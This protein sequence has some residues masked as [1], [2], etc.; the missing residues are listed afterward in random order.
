MSKN[1]V[2]WLLRLGLAFVFLYAS[3]SSFLK[4]YDWVGYIPVWIKEIIDGE[5][6]LKIHA[7]AEFILGVWLLSGKFIPL[8]AILSAASLLSIIIASFGAMDIIFRDIGLLFA[9]LALLFLHK[10]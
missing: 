3:V 10:R 1:L 7:I 9:A 6:L 2:S 8:A 4:P 5:I